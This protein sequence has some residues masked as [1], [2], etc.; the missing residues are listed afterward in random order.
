MSRLSPSGGTATAAAFSPLGDYLFVTLQ[1]NNQVVV[2]DALEMESLA[3]FGSLVG[4]FGTGL[5]PQGVC[6]DPPTEQ[7]FVKNLMGRG[8]M[9]NIAPSTT[10]IQLPGSITSV[11]AQATTLAK[12]NSVAQR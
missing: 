4:R 2:L 3:G 5:A 8:V 11:D 7:V 1:G 12:N 9:A 6:V 10:M